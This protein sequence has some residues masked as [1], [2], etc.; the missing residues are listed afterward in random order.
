MSPVSSVVHLT[1]LAFFGSASRLLE[2]VD[3]PSRLNTVD[4]V[5]PVVFVLSRNTV[6]VRADMLESSIT[7][8]TPERNLL[9]GY[10]VGKL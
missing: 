10:S 7:Y 3:K 2:R 6:L 5:R 4:R 8:S 9:P 1:P